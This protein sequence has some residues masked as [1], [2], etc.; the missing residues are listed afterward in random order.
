MLWRPHLTSKPPSPIILPSKSATPMTRRP[1]G[2]ARGV[3]YYGYKI[4]AATDAKDGFILC[5]HTT[6]ANHSDTKEFERLVNAVSL[7]PAS[8]V[9]ADKGYCNGA[10][11]DALLERGLEDGTMDKTPRGGRLTD[12]EKTRNRT[13]SSVRQVIERGFGTM[14]RGYDFARSRYVGQEK[15]NGEFH[16]MAMAFN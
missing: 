1:P 15:V 11:R 8:W 13:I 3:A 16:L 7:A 2:C 5:G 9:Y 6:A 14:K 4:H 12:F 10:N